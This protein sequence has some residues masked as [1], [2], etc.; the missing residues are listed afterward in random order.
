VSQAL[1]DGWTFSHPRRARSGSDAAPDELGRVTSEQSPRARIADIIRDSGKVGNDQP[2]PS[3]DQLAAFTAVIS[4][5]SA[6]TVLASEALVD[7][8]AKRFPR[9]STS[10]VVERDFDAPY[11]TAGR[12]FI[13][14][15]QAG[16]FILNAAF[17]TASGAM[18]EVKKPMSLLA[19]AYTVTATINDGGATTHLKAQA[20]HTGM[21]LGQN[22][23][24]LNQ[25]FDK[26][27]EYLTLFK[28]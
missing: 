27:N 8:L 9:L 5:A 17:D 18:L 2:G 28:A 14:A 7:E 11:E 12:A 19:V 16:D 13:L 4:G 22:A 26:T 6:G 21:D 23:K 15:L 10:A 1:D 20:T 3:Q 24:L 25:L